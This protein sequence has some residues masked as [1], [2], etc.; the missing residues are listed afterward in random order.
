[1]STSKTTEWQNFVN[2]YYGCLADDPIEEV[3]WQ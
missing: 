2:Q 3:K 1:M